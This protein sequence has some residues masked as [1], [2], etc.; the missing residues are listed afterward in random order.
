MVASAEG[1]VGFRSA[2]AENLFLQ[3]ARTNPRLRLSS[4]HFGVREHWT[5]H[6]P[7]P[8]WVWDDTSSV[9]GSELAIQLQNRHLSGATLR[10]RW[11][12]LRGITCS[13]DHSTP[14]LLLA[15]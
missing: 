10:V 5:V 14:Q 13:H 1:W 11:L 4:R 3:A 15:I 9:Y 6:P 2:H 12:L 8:E 7:L